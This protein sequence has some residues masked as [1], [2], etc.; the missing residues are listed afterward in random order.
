MVFTTTERIVSGKV[1]SF[2]SWLEYTGRDH[3]HHRLEALGLGRGQV[4]LVI[5]FLSLAVGMSAIVLYEA[6]T[7]AGFLLL[8]QTV[9]IYAVFA[10]LELLGREKIRRRAQA[11]GK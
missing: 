2:R 4:V 8:L 6:E 3:L 9:C 7:Y 10:L 5:C 1:T 11:V